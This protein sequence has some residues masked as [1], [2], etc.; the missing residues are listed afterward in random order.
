[1][2]QKKRKQ[3]KKKKMKLYEFVGRM[4]SKKLKKEKEKM[5]LSNQGKG[6]TIKIWGTNNVNLLREIYALCMKEKEDFWKPSYEFCMKIR[7][8]RSLIK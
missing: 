4:I 5:D 2:K 1:M 7:E 8:E 6:D 3:R